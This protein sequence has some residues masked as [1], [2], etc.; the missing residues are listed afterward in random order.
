MLGQIGH[1]GNQETLDIA[2][3]KFNEFIKE[4]SSLH[5]DLRAIVYSL[6]AQN[7][8]EAEYQSLW[9]LHSKANLH[10][11]RVRILGSLTRFQDK[12]LLDDLLQRSLSDEV[13]SQDTVLVVVSTANNIGARDLTWEF[14]K[15][16]WNE[17][18]RRYGKGGFAIMNLVTITGLFT[19]IEK[20]EEVE[21][22]FQAN[23]AP[24]AERTIQQSLER[25][26]LNSKW[27]DQNRD[28]LDEWFNK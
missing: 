10:E 13:R 3:T 9:D 24:S 19:E 15:N 26:Q 1:Y 12:E 2:K 17:F 7:G 23:P 8:G 28:N 25:I 18:D 27:L 5:P 11:E 4:P 22:F 16:N 6:V 14:V 20:V 21:S